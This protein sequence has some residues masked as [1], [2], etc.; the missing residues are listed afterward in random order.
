M[1]APWWL[2]SVKSHFMH[3]ELSEPDSR[4]SAVRQLLLVIIGLNLKDSTLANLLLK[5]LILIEAAHGRPRPPYAPR[6]PQHLLHLASPRKRLLYRKLLITHRPKHRCESFP[7]SPWRPRRR[8]LRKN[9]LPFF[10]VSL[11][12]LPGKGRR[13]QTRA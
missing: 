8:Y 6:M 7:A 4:P 10:P 9:S 11:L 5:V 2:E 3:Y 1:V 13:V 12:L